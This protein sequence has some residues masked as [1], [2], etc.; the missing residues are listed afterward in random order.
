[1]M[2]G[3]RSLVRVSQVEMALGI[4]RRSLQRL[5]E[6]YIGVSPK[7]VLARYRM[8]DVVT[9][10]DEGYVG[11]LGELA[12]E[13]GWFDQAHFTRDFTRLVGVPPG[14]YRAGG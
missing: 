7:W 14:E 3:D 5:F 11:P 12:A 6:R 9:A 8:H 13:H 2:L 10:L 4:G 1:M